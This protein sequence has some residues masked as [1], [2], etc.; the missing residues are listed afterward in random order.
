MRYDANGNLI[1]DEA[2]RTL[3][4]DALNRLQSVDGPTGA[5]RY[6]YDPEDVLSGMSQ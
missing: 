1:Q 6:H 2:G 5:A 4:Y 3:T